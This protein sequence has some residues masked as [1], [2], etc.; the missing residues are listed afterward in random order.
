VRAVDGEPDAHGGGISVLGV[1]GSLRGASYNTALLRA[2][3][4]VAPEGMAIEL[5]EGL[6]AIPPY[7]EDVEAS[8]DP[9]P[10]GAFKDA[11]RAADAVLFATPEYN[12]GIPGLLKNAIDWAS[13]PP[14]Q[15][16]LD[17]K[18][19]AVMGA[20]IGIGGTAQAQLQLRQALVFP[21]AQTMPEPEL[22]VSRVR[23]KIDA[24]GRLTDELTR[25]ALRDLLSA[26]VG[27]IEQVRAL[28]A[29]A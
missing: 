27:W 15:S 18:P 5:F 19:V 26:F 11:I 17:R 21:G 29:A 13:R 1:S 22:L 12:H 14:R 6:G 7:D 16:A 9:A 24:E 25:A 28:L 20:S 3:A 10:V 8:G 2:A 4:E 23:D